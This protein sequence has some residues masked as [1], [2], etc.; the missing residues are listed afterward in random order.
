MKRLFVKNTRTGANVVF[1]LNIPLIPEIWQEPASNNNKK[2]STSSHSKAFGQESA[3]CVFLLCPISEGAI[4]SPATLAGSKHHAWLLCFST[5]APDDAPA[6]IS[7]IDISCRHSASISAATGKIASTF[8]GDNPENAAIAWVTGIF[9][10]NKMSLA[11]S[12]KEGMFSG[13]G[14]LSN[15]CFSVRQ[16]SKAGVRL[17]NANETCRSGNCRC[18]ASAAVRLPAISS[19]T[20]SNRSCIFAIDSLVARW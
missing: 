8:A 4:N 12:A 5:H 17:P 13:N 16:T 10:S 18:S 2:N 19:L 1:S 9:F 3:F 14:I 15:V 6:S 20:R 7:D 11:Q